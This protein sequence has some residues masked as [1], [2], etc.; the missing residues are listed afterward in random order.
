ME[1]RKYA[2]SIK[3]NDSL[4]GASKKTLPIDF[5]QNY[6]PR[7]LLSKCYQTSQEKFQLPHNLP[8]LYPNLICEASVTWMLKV[9]KNNIKRKNYRIL[10]L[11]NKSSKVL[12]KLLGKQIQQ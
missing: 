3:E 5:L 2:I 4:G 9:D 6:R 11:M 10:S 7:W 8:K 12:N 1:N